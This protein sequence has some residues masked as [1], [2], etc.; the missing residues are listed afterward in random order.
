[1][2]RGLTLAELARRVG[3]S[4]PTLHRY[5]S[6]WDRFEVATLR[7]IAAAL[8]ARLEIRLVAPSQAVPEAPSRRELVRSFAPLFWNHRLSVSDLERH[9]AF[10]LERVLTS[11]SLE[12][13]RQARAHYGDEALRKAVARRSVDPRTRAYWTLILGG[14]HRAPQGSPR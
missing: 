10:V 4:A 13:V 1:M 9:P 14:K 7:R 2:A 3:T 8:G 5:E 6:G 11:G 12:Q